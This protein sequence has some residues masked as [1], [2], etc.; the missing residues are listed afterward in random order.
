M[1]WRT[2]AAVCAGMV[3]GMMAPSLG[4][5]AHS[6]RG[7]GVQVGVRVE[8]GAA[9]AEEEGEDEEDWEDEEEAVQL[10][11]NDRFY[12]DGITAK[13]L[14]TGVGVPSEEELFEGLRCVGGGYA[15]KG[16]IQADLDTLLSTG[17]F[18]K[19]DANV[20]PGP[21]GYYV[22]F[23]FTAKVWPKMRSFQ[24]RGATILPPEIPAKIVQGFADEKYCTV[25]TLAQSKAAIEEWYHDRGFV[26]GNVSS[27]DGMETGSIIAHVTEGQISGVMPMYQQKDGTFKP[28][29][30]TNNHVVQRELPFKVGAIYNIEDGKR[31]LRDVFSLNLFDNVQVVPRQDPSNPEKVVVEVVLK[32]RAPQSAD[33]ELEWGI[34]PGEMGRPEVVS[35]RPGGSVYAEH[36]NIKGEGRLLYGHIATGNFLSPQDD[37]QFKL[38]Y[39]HP[40]LLGDDDPDKT[41]F[42]AMAFNSRKLSPVF[43]DNTGKQDDQA[44]VWIDRAGGKVTVAKNYSRQSRFVYGVVAQEVTT[45]DESGGIVTNGVKQTPQGMPAVGPPTT[46]GDTGRDLNVYL[47]GNL[48]RD[49]TYFKNGAVLG[50][51]DILEVNQ[52]VGIGTRLP[53]FN[54]HVLTMTRF[55]QLTEPK[56]KSGT[57]AVLVAHVKAGN[58]LGDLA[59]YDAFVLGGPHSVRG[60]N[61]G[62]LGV[63][64][65]F[66]ETSMELRVP[67][68]K[69]Q[70]AYG[71][72]E[73]ATDLG[74]G[75][76]VRGN[77]TQFYRKP[78]GGSAWGV[79]MKLGAVRAEWARDSISQTGTW[80]LRFGE[81]F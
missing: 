70:V 50:G 61:Q 45:R 1:G 62:E 69:R 64:R 74:S 37:L 56:K 39:N 36:R 48:T 12:I 3:A 44:A 46:H 65:R 11:D 2:G 16:D 58:A 59:T 10:G 43:T 73:N 72:M 20:T 29:S 22:E 47:Q 77:P 66:L 8:R 41:N 79:G 38:E 75:A 21:R 49:N 23:K 31:A 54:R 51:R 27:F 33:V 19:V 6:A 25:P 40:Y 4:V 34:A 15:V 67:V 32:E 81:R 35:L 24:V 76:E 42:R 5:V 53:V 26:F 9:L 52:G 68:W 60:F 30:H 63:A 18:Q 7:G 57:P 17:L 28:V 80:F 55:L 13:N 71:F 78:G 14:V